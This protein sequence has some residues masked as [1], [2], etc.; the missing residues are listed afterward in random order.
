MLASN[1]ATDRAAIDERSAQ[2]HIERAGRQDPDACERGICWRRIHG[3]GTDRDAHSHCVRRPPTPD[4]GRAGWRQSGRGRQTRSGR[5]RGGPTTP[6]AR[7]LP[8]APDDAARWNRPTFVRYADN[9]NADGEHAKSNGNNV[10]RLAK[11]TAATLTDHQSF[12]PAHGPSGAEGRERRYAEL[13][14]R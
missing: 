13:S 10:G 2:S 14:R 4:N 1:A 11:A 6:R 12:Q 3:R 7:R 5:P 9:V 8:Q